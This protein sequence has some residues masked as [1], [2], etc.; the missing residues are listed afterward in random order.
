[1]TEETPKRTTTKITKT[2]TRRP[3]RRPRDEEI[4]EIFENGFALMAGML[5]A[6]RESDVAKQLR[7]ES[8]KHLAEHEK[9]KSHVAGTD[10][11]EL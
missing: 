6:F 3:R 7:I 11:V 8:A 9:L 5:A 4:S 1:M 2:P 10:I